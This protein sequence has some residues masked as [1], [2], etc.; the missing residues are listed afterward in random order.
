MTTGESTLSAGGQA[1]D[2]ANTGTLTVDKP[3]DSAYTF[4][5]IFIVPLD[6]CCA[7]IRQDAGVGFAIIMLVHL[8]AS[9]FL[10]MPSVS[11]AAM[12]RLGVR[13]GC[14]VAATTAMGT[15]CSCR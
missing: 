14:L 1:V 15:P 6:S 2:S 4:G 10:P 7:E 8:C 11:N 9:A 12:H 3:T 13:Q 5:I